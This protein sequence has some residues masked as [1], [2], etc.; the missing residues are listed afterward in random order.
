[1]HSKLNPRTS[2][3]SLKKA[4]KKAQGGAAEAAGG[5]DDEGEGGAAG[6]LLQ[7]AGGLLARGAALPPGQ[8][9][10]TRLKDANQ[11]RQTGPAGCRCL[12]H[13]GAA[14]LIRQGS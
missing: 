1:M 13:P 8:L 6:A 5:S 7:R 14:R 2:W 4:R 3:A 9:E 10:T 12:Q 11:V